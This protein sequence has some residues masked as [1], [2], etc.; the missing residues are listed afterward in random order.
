M[1]DVEDLTRY[2]LSFA[3]NREDIMLLAIFGQDYQGVYVDLGAGHPVKSSTTKLLYRL[4]WRGVSF[5]PQPALRQ[6]TAYDRSR[7]IVLNTQ[8]TS[9]AEAVQATQTD[10]IDFCRLDIANGAQLLQTN[11]WSACRPKVVAIRR[12]LDSGSLTD[13]GYTLLVEDG[14]WAYFSDGSWTSAAVLASY[15]QLIEAASHIVDS[16]IANFV[17]VN[18]KRGQ[19]AQHQASKED[20]SRIPSMKSL[21]VHI[22]DSLNVLRHLAKERRQ[23]GQARFETAQVPVAPADIDDIAQVRR[24]VESIDQLYSQSYDYHEAKQA[25]QVA[26]T[27]AGRLARKA[28]L[29]GLD[30]PLVLLEGARATAKRRR[31]S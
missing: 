10:T 5:E 24:Y 30:M 8:P 16:D 23:G 22:R 15:R 13:N 9:L 2:R 27:R 7:D 14:L 17:A 25:E 19:A 26:K 12:S 20:D 11:D 1:S 18:H 29:A 4:G 28:R 3:S 6:L 21:K 31:T